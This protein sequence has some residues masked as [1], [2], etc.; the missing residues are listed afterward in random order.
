MFA[1]DLKIFNRIGTLADCHLL[2]NELACM[3]SWFNSMGLQF[4]IDKCHSM[5]FS[6]RRSIITFTYVINGSNL[7]SVK[8]NVLYLTPR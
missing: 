8:N 5:S 2:Q 7:E 1:D 6:R 4:N 3:V